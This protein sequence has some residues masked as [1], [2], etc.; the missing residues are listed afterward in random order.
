[1]LLLF[2]GLFLVLVC[3]GAILTDMDR[4]RRQLGEL[5]DRIE[6]LVD[7]SRRLHVRNMRG[8]N[9]SLFYTSNLLDQLEHEVTTNERGKGIGPPEDEAR[10]SWRPG[11]RFRD[12]TTRVATFEALTDLPHETD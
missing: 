7:R 6:P 1:M 10:F 11:R 2:V 3:L 4:R 5:L 9:G 12:L 8:L